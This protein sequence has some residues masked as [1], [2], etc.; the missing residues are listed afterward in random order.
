[1]LPWP[2]TLLEPA[3]RVARPAGQVPPGRRPFC[4]SAFVVC[5]PPATS[6]P[7]PRHIPPTPH[8]HPPHNN[9][10]GYGIVFPYQECGLK[11]AVLAGRAAA[12]YAIGKPSSQEIRGGTA[13]GNEACHAPWEGVGS[14][15]GGA[16]SIAPSPSTTLLS[17][18]GQQE[19]ELE[20]AKVAAGEQLGAGEALTRTWQR[21]TEQTVCL[22]YGQLHHAALR[23]SC[24]Q[25]RA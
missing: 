9:D 23:C 14:N 12:A 4:K 17:A 20:Q 22:L 13:T 15:Q 21:K 3:V 10:N 8:A 11:K 7:H 24:P 1:M 6:L 18:V 5:R 2:T 19:L 16:S 25:G